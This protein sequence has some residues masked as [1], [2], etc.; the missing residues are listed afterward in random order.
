MAAG[1][2]QLKPDLPFTPGVEAPA[3][4]RKSMLPT[5]SRSAIASL[6]KCG[7]VF[8]PKRPW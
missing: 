6:S 2:Y 1:E 4:S 8:T 5:L 7:M 3:W